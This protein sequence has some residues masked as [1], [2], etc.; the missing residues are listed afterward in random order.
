MGFFCTSF[1]ET[2]G[3]EKTPTDKTLV[4]ETAWKIIKTYLMLNTDYD[5]LGPGQRSQYFGMNIADKKAQSL[6]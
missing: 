3:Y 6:L 5:F 2:E 1:N 4:M